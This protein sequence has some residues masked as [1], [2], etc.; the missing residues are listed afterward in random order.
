ALA[1]T[2]QNAP[3]PNNMT[4]SGIGDNQEPIGVIRLGGKAVLSGT[5]TRGGD[6]R[7]AGSS[8]NGNIPLTYDTYPAIN[9]D[10]TTL[11]I[12]PSHLISGKITGPFR[13]DVGAGVSVGTNFKL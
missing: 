9:P 1:N 8:N 6:A 5:L 3:I 4:L 12:D 2:A 7:I 13:L 11:Y 10:G